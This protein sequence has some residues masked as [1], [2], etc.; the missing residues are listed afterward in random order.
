MNE[1]NKKD[2]LN[3]AIQKV[4]S[5]SRLA[6]AC[7]VSPQAV[8]AWVIRGEVPLQRCKDVRKATGISLKKLRPDYF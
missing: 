4:G 3:L 5:M 1:M 2:G 7:G 8:R 6:R